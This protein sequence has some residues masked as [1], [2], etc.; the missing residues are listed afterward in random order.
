MKLAALFPL[1]LFVAGCDTLNTLAA[2]PG[3]DPLSGKGVTGDA[4]AAEPLAG[5]PVFT[6]RKPA[7]SPTPGANTWA[8]GRDESV[9][10]E[11]TTKQGRFTYVNMAAQV[12]KTYADFA[13]TF[14]MPAGAAASSVAV[15]MLLA[16][17]ATYTLSLYETSG[18]DVRSREPSLDGGAPT[19][20]LVYHD[21]AFPGRTAMGTGH[22][23]TGTIDDNRT[24]TQVASWVT[25]ALDAPVQLQ[26]GKTYA[27]GLEA[28]LT[29]GHPDL[30]NKAAFGL[31][32]TPG[33]DYAGG[34]GGYR[35]S[36]EI[37]ENGVRGPQWRPAD[38]DLDACF[39]IYTRGPVDGPK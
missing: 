32:I 20:K 36:D 37:D 3:A 30:G 21:D 22:V 39:R 5:A 34:V 18:E 6:K 24:G 19:S 27:W 13:Q 4:I 1:V 26:A 17:D 29:R 38:A 11:H 25:F 31:E 7:P 9:V 12:P 35:T 28:S 8:P 33:Y 23:T 14:T 15:L 2:A 16:S 10:L